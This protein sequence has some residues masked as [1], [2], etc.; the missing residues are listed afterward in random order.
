M[1]S[2]YDSESS[3][4][5]SNLSDENCCLSEIDLDLLIDTNESKITQPYTSPT[6]N[7]I[8]QQGIL[9]NEAIESYKILK[10]GYNL[11]GLVETSKIKQICCGKNVTNFTRHII[12]IHSTE[13]EVA[14][15][16]SLPKGSK[17]RVELADSLR[18]WG[19]FLNNVGDV[20][21]IK[22]VRRPNE[23]SKIVPDASNYLPCKHC[24]GMYKK[25][26][27]YRHEKTWR[28]AKTKHVGRNRAQVSAQNL[29]LAFSNTDQEL[30]SGP[31][32][33]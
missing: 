26:Y 25:K 9:N 29:L 2:E 7:K 31:R 13:F 28:S 21:V 17:E 8:K 18:K 10:P 27:L 3:Y 5:P 15:Y 1:N 22:P 11:N 23:C 30:Y 4:L 33:K 14:K 32:E 12:R 16:I 6:M 20:E 19:N 24:Y